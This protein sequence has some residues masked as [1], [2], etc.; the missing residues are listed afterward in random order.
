MFYTSFD[1]S[2]TLLFPEGKGR[3]IYAGGDDFLGVLYSEEPLTKM[4]ELKP[5]KPKP[6]K[7]IEAWDWLHGLPKHWKSLQENLKTELDLECTYS[8]GFVWAGNRVP[9]R[10]ILQHCREAEKRS[11]NLD[12]DRVTIRVVFNSGQFVQWTCPWDCLHILGSY[13][14]RDGQ[15]GKKA[16]WTHL[17]NDW[18]Q[19]QARHAVNLKQRTENID[20][21][22]ALALFKIYFGD[23]EEDFLIQNCQHLTGKDY[24]SSAIIEWIDGLVK[25]GWQLCSNS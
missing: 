6:V 10:D 22:I 14:D 24:S 19:L 3:V 18:A 1:F 2:N 17:Y 21:Y 11:K 4:E 15:T 9:Q 5:V 20:D 25:I 7:P 8:L 12:R 13:R 23:Q 16:S